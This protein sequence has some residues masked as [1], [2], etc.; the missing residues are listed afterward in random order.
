MLHLS[1]AELTALATGEII[2][3]FVARG[4]LTEGD[5]IELVGSGPSSPAS[6]KAA[7]RRWAQSPTLD[8]HGAVVVSVDPAAILDPTSGATRHI[9]SEPG[10]GD[11]VVLRVFG[12]GGPVLS[13]EAF[14]ARLRSVE[15][16]LRE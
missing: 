9:R 12:P 3:A 5:E 14:A 15:G 4:T 16:S 10:D 11:V 1:N 13:E 6:L 8:G 7:Y 2:V